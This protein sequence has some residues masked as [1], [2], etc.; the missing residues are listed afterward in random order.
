MLKIPSATDSPP[1]LTAQRSSL[2]AKEAQISE[3][4]PPTASPSTRKKHR[5]SGSK[6]DD[7]PLSWEHQKRKKS[8][9]GKRGMTAFLVGGTVLFG[10]MVALV[11]YVL[12]KPSQVTPVISSPVVAL[13]EFPLAEEKDA[14]EIRSSSW[15]ESNLLTLGEPVAKG[16]LNATS[17]DEMLKWVSEPTKVE[18][19]MRKW[20]PGGKIEPVGLSDFSSSNIVEFSD[21]KASLIIR[22]RDFESKLLAFVNTPDGMKIDWESFVGWSELTWE[23]FLE[24][25]PTEP[26]KFRLTAALTQY[27]NFDFLDEN[28]WRSYQLTSPD[29]M[30]VIYGYAELDSEIDRKLQM[31]RGGVAAAMILELKFPENSASKNQVII[32]KFVSDGWVEG[33]EDKP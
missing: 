8:S 4:S 7:E 10:G 33:V 11:L 13:P 30:T 22:T 32:E 12:L 19:L 17:V 1:P 6:T 28:K 14:E 16:F 18:P 26:K 9:D 27:Y 15:D 29:G 23:E 3:S 25:R 2:T 21:G 24:T 20:Y 31:D 5:R